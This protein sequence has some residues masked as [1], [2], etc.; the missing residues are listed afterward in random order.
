MTGT[1]RQL[2]EPRAARTAERVWVLDDPRAGTSAQAIGIA[3]Q[4]GVPFRRIPLSWNWMAHVAAL[5]RRGS[6]LG[7]SL[8]SGD[9]DARVRPWTMQTTMVTARSAAPRLVISAGSRSAA[10][11]L[12]LKA[13]FGCRLVHCMRPGLAGLFRASAYDMLVI[14]EHDRPSAGENVFRTLGAPHRL[15]P[16]LLRQAAASWQERLDHL[17]HPRVTLAVGGGLSPAQA[18][19]LGRDIARLAIERGGAVLAT[20]SRRTSSESTEALSAGLGRAMHLLYRWGEPGENPYRGFLAAADVV[21]VT[22]DSV[23]MLSEA[24]AGIAPVFAALPE[25]AG[26]RHRRFLATLETRGQVRPL[27]DDLSPWPRTPLDEA[28][29]VAHEILRRFPLELSGPE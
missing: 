24:C 25:L 1:A 28:G 23:S 7:L 17:P 9:D 6:L 11:G 20:T 8:P 16:L 21:V 29:R 2:R 27:G 5:A 15:S 26:F 10:V 12:W 13:R 3:E 4:L 18:N 19:T 14:P 22:A